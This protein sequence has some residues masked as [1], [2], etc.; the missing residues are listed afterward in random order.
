MRD[1]ATIE[2]DCS[3]GSV[4]I[5]RD[6]LTLVDSSHQQQVSKA[7]LIA[8]LAGR[9][10]FSLMRKNTTQLRAMKIDALTEP[11]ISSS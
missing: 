9:Y 1:A 11:E 10:A 7:E 2:I 5:D 3:E 8:E 6:R 4:S